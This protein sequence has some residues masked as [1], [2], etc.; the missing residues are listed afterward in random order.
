MIASLPADSVCP[1]AQQPS[2]QAG[3]DLCSGS[4]RGCPGTRWEPGPGDPSGLR[5]PASEQRKVWAARLAG[6]WQADSTLR[7]R[8]ARRTAT[9]LSESHQMCLP[10]AE[11]CEA[12]CLAPRHASD[13]D[14]GRPPSDGAG[15]RSSGAWVT[16][17][18]MVLPR[19][20]A[21]ASSK[22]Y[23]LVALTKT[24]SE[25]VKNGLSS[26]KTLFPSKPQQ[27]SS[28]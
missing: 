12:H 13:A 7:A 21:K 18:N 19:G 6:H 4:G 5:A 28:I 2:L 17:R 23:P 15:P 3:S 16:S 1:Q 9:P 14:S 8:L 10:E 11:P 26:L 20:H 27:G 25:G 24:L 22:S